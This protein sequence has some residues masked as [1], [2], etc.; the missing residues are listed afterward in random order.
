MIAALNRST[1]VIEFTLDGLILE[2]NDNFLKCMGYSK[3][4]ILGKHHQI[5]CTREEVESKSYHDFWA[6]L[7]SGQFITDRFKR[8]NSNG[9]EIWLEASYNPVYDDSGELY[10]VIKFATDITEQMNREFAITETSQ[11]AYDT[12]IQTETDTLKGIKVIESTTMTMNE[13]SEQMDSASKGIFELNT[14]SMK[15]SDLVENI[16]GI[17]DQTNLLALNAAIEAARAGE[18]GRGFAVVA[19]EVR[20]LASRT[21][22]AT[23]DIIKVVGDNKVLTENAVALIEQSMEKATKAL[24]LSMEAGVVIDD[25]QTGAR[26]VLNAISEFNQKRQ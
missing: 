9:N 11:I 13:L 25:I 19:D 5:F 6:N 14:Q 26:K 24:T 23:E 1:A 3:K 15:V 20:Q 4:Q 12:S 2:A 17:A 8:I 7:Q 21:S 16:R 18:Q 10:K 22:L